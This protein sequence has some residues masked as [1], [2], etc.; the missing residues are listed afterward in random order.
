LGFNWPRAI[1]SIRARILACGAMPIL[2]TF[3]LTS[4]PSGTTT[5]DP[6]RVGI[7]VAQDALAS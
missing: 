1:A 3:I 4:L 6:D 2:T 7:V 5:T